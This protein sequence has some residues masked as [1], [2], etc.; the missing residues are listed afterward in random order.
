[1]R[2]DRIGKTFPGKQFRCFSSIIH[3]L[4]SDSE[5]GTLSSFDSHPSKETKCQQFLVKEAWLHLR[6]VHWNQPIRLAS[7]AFFSGYCQKAKFKIK[8]L[9]ELIA[10]REGAQKQKKS[11]NF[12][13]GFPVC[14]QKRIIEG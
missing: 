3:W 7:A 12:C 8:K 11:P 4:A 5:V 10:R 13:T 1:V 9:S 6:K 2:R 14:I